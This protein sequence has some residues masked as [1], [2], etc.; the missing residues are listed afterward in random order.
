MDKPTAVRLSI[1]VSQESA[2]S[3]TF[4][5]EFAEDGHRSSQSQATARRGWPDLM[6]SP[7]TWLTLFGDITDT[8]L[9]LSS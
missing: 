4:D 5:D 8:C 1:Q 9:P 7:G 3:M 2:D 6:Y